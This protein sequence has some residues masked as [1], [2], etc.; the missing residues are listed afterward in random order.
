MFLQVCI[1]LLKS[2]KKKN[3]SILKHMPVKGRERKSLLSSLEGRKEVSSK[4]GEEQGDRTDSGKGE[5]VDQWCCDVWERQRGMHPRDGVHL[6][7]R[8][9]RD[10]GAREW[11]EIEILTLAECAEGERGAGVQPEG[12]E[13]KQAPNKH[14]RERPC[15]LLLYVRP[16][17]YQ[18][19]YFC[20]TRVIFF[21]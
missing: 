11:G 2:K 20:E 12:H 14:R 8:W 17:L 16:Q 15:S 3:A 21:D 7:W 9:R 13:I 18:R 1:L 19:L 4:T 5:Y 10:S 6:P